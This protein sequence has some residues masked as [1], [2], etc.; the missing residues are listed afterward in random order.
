MEIS[1]FL[2]E[3]ESS[4]RA[5]ISDIHSL[6][7]TT[8]KKVK[9]EVSMMMGKKTLIYKLNGIFIYGISNAK[10]HISLHL[11]PIYGLP[12][13]HAK[14]LK[15]LDKAKFQKG[16]INFEKAEQMP[17]PIVKKLLEDCARID[18][19]AMMEKYKKKK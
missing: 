3:I 9:P 18:Y 5:I 15:L 11:M 7:L 8:N 16:C 2:S 4:R 10:N 12:E 14:Y 6:I 1:V 13:L 17:L 19:N